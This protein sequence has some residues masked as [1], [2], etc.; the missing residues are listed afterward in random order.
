MVRQMLHLSEETTS[1]ETV[2]LR[3]TVATVEVIIILLSVHVAVR[4]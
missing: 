1:V 2:V 3:L 4:A